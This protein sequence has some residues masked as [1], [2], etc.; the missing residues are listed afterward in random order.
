MT[1]KQS[2]LFEQANEF[3]PGG[4]HSPVRSFK[5]L[6]STPRFIKEGMGAYISDVE[7]KSYID[8][9]MSFG[10]LILGHQD[11]DV[12][13]ALRDALDRGWSFGAS[14]PY[15]LEL[16]RYLV[17]RICFIDKVRFVNSGTEAVMTALRIARGATG[18]D[19]IIKFNGCYHGHIDSM[20]IKAGSGL[21]GT[22]EASSAG[23]SKNVAQETIV[24]E[25]GDEKSVEACLKDNSDQIAAI[26]IEPLPANNGLLIQHK[27]FLTFLREITRKYGVLLIH[28][29]VIS[30]FRIG[31]FQGMSCH[32]GIFP[33]LVTYGKVIGGGLPVGAVA[34]K[35]EFM[36]LLAPVGPVYQA[37]TLS[38]NPLAMI[39]GMA[40]LKKM[41]PAAYAKL[42]EQTKNIVDVFSKW[43]TDYKDGQFSH[44]HIVQKDSLFWF[45]SKENVRSIPEL[46][47]KIS[48]Q[49]L[50]LFETL[51]EKG[52]YLAPN[53]YEVGF[54]SLSHDDSVVHELK[55]RLW[56]KFIK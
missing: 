28:D 3:I 10:P 38:A 5:G 19:K 48:E 8:F 25:L 32:A 29:E 37:G 17:E 35:K 47:S 7:G 50:P 22:A 30:G 16:A 21:A 20:L 27:E 18:K 23:I 54:C 45:V 49:F 53:A 56:D 43:L 24:L 55:K 34:G 13:E 2:T 14:E 40:T 31:G 39:G 36:D 9:C 4:V 33:D 26:I 41:T 42:R 44:Y 12:K 11:N 51:L 1:D 15:S 6:K 46:P 52:V